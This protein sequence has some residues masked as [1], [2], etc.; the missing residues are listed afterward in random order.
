MVFIFAKLLK[1]RAEAD[2]NGGS[3]I[4]HAQDGHGQG[5]AQHIQT[6]SQ[7]GLVH[8]QLLSAPGNKFSNIF[9]HTITFSLFLLFG[10]YISLKTNATAILSYSDNFNGIFLS[11]ASLRLSEIHGGFPLLQR[12]A[13][14]MPARKSVRLWDKMLFFGNFSNILPINGNVKLL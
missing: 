9:I 13:R 5:K 12:S 3:A 14:I 1:L 6:G 4:G 8:A 11:S 7:L 10:L 2:R